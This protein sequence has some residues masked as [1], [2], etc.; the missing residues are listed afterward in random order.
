MHLPLSY[1]LPLRR[2]DDADLGELAAY[3]RSLASHVEMI[4]VDGSDPWLWHRADAAFGVGVLHL[5]VD[6]SL[7]FLNGKVAG[8]TTGVHAASHERVVIADDDVRYDLATLQRLCTLLD[9][10][11]LVR[12][13]NYF[14]PLPWHAV[15]DTARTLLNRAVADDY[16]GTLGLRRSRFLAMGGYDGNVLFENLELIRTV[17]ASGGRV[18]SSR[19]L[20]VA[21]RPP[22]VP[23][24]WSQRVRQAYDD[25]ASP[26]RLALFLSLIPVLAGGARMW[27]WK[28]PVAAAGAAM[29]LAEVGRRR[30]GAARAF[31][32]V[33]SVVSPLWLLE[34]ATCSWIALGSRLLVGGC[35]YR[36]TIITTAAHSRR[37]LRRRATLGAGHGDVTGGAP[38][39]LVAAVT[40]RLTA[41]EATSAQRDRPSG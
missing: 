39:G 15:W 29:V 13:Q 18:A 7:M 3:V 22:A 32:A 21:R 28:A 1:V 20:L 17:E 16:P 35:R 25:F 19:D 14:E 2:D 24:F 31:P 6:P 8:V 12:P 4:V 34:R 30:G 38:D 40:P 27:G 11:D 10:A 41:R 37:H 9:Q 5:R 23:R 33:A 26:G 36:G